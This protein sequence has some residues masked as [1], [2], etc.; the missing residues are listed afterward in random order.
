MADF[1][2]KASAK[3][4]QAVRQ[5]LS[6]IGRRG[7]GFLKDETG[8]RVQWVPRFG[9][10][11]SDPGEPPRRQYP[12]MRGD[13]V[14]LWSSFKYRVEPRA[15]SVEDLSIYTFDPKAPILEGGSMYMEA[16]PFMEPLRQSMGNVVPLFKSLVSENLTR[17]APSIGAV[18]IPEE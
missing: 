16:R 10:V 5:A 6:E 9:Y 14:E 1:A 3:V 13:R 11:R 2:E 18:F 15:T 4:R 8:V 17:M 7:V 12:D